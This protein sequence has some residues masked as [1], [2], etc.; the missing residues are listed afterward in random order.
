MRV[1][2]PNNNPAASIASQTAPSTQ[3]AAQQAT[4]QVGQT[5]KTAQ[6][7]PIRV[8]TGGAA[9]SGAP[10][11]DEVQLS[12][13]SNKLNELQSG[14]AEREQYLESLRLE[15]ASGQYNADPAELSKKIVDDMLRAD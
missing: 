7:D 13:L 14:S 6:L 12:S 5:A 11:T 9:T 2:D 4:Q 15:V 1:N 3:Q 8:S 10:K